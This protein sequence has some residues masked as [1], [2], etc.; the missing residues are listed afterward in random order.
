MRFLNKLVR[1]G[2]VPPLNQD[3][4]RHLTGLYRA[5][6][7][8]ALE[9]NPC[10]L[11]FVKGLPPDCGAPFASLDLKVTMLKPGWFPCIPGWHLDDFYRP[12]DGTPNPQP[13][14]L[15]LPQHNSR[16]FAVVYGDC[17]LTEFLAEP[18]TLPV[19]LPEDCKGPLY[20]YYNSLI[21]DRERSECLRLL[22]AP[23]TLWEFDSLTWHRGTAAH[24]EGW[25]AFVRL[26]YGTTR[27]PKNEI[28]N[29]TNVYVPEHLWTTGW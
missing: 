7:A 3:Q 26:T 2:R 5:D 18:I 13:L 10:L 14:L 11:D 27:P 8:F 6:L 25:R 9:K 28:R 16:H 12:Q 4:I 17:S 21:G 19:P 1:H 20:G 15:D 29:Q 22:T 24:K 23:E